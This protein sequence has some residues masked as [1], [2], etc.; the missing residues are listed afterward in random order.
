MYDED[1][2]LKYPHHHNWFNKLYV[3]EQ[4]GYDC[5]PCGFAPSKSNYYIV[6]PIYNLGGMGVGTSVQYIEA[7]DYT[8]VPPGYFWCEILL[9]KQYSATY[10]FVHGGLSDGKPYW[11][12]ISCWVGEKAPGSFSKFT[13]W[14]R[15]SYV[16]EVPRVFNVLSDVKRINVEFKGNSPFEVHLRDTPDPDYDVLIPIWN[17]TS[18]SDIEWYLSQGFTYVSSPDDSNGFLEVAREGFMVK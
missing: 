4:M 16:P 6:R 13:Q 5:G 8:M 14:T 12:P 17:D 10:E 15:S 18:L 1:A 9:G 11:K 7:N 3:A 2:W